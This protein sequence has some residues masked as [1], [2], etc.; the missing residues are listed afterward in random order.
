MGQYP[1]LPM[2]EAEAR[3]HEERAAYWREQGNEEYAK[4]SDR[5]ALR[6]RKRQAELSDLLRG[7]SWFDAFVAERGSA[8]MRDMEDA[9]LGPTPSPSPEQPEPTETPPSA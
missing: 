5:K 3:K 6:W 7:E 2:F 9:L 4:G 8:L 1:F